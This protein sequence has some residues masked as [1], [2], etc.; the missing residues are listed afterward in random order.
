MSAVKNC[1]PSHE[2]KW[3][4]VKRGAAYSLA[5][6]A[7]VTTIASDADAQVVY[8]GLQ[9]IAIGQFSSQ[10]LNLD[11]DAYNDILL[12]NYVFGGGNYQGAYVNFAPGKV[13]GFNAGLNY[14]SALGAGFLVDSVATTGGP[15]SAS[16]AYASNPNSQ[17]DNVTDAYIGLEFPINATSH[18]GW[19][20]VDIDNAAGTFLIKDWA[21][22]SQPGVGIHTGEIPEPSTL[23]LLAAGALGV[24]ALRRKKRESN[25]S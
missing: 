17:F 3:N 5:A 25:L 15:F 9:N 12:K 8:S 11:G 16:M 14:V 18:F 20:R 2:S 10:N 13:V 23:G 7:A 19:I 24:A 6:G 22:E 4:S 1:S 21:Y